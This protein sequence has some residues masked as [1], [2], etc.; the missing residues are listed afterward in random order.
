MPSLPFILLTLILATRSAGADV[1]VIV[2]AS[3][4]VTRLDK[5]QVS[6]LFLGK[7]ATFPDGS[8][9]VPLD[10]DNASGLHTEFHD[11]V[12][13]KSVSQLRAYWSKL[14]FTGKASPPREIPDSRAIR[15]LIATNPNMIGYI[16]KGSVAPGVRVVYTP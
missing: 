8:Q 16:D 1:V 9:A 14:V 2:N 3:S 5:N 13:G 12:T 7:A 4:P 6:D 15:S 10:Q 11:K